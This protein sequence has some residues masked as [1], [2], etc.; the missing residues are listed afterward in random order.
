MRFRL[1]KPK[2]DAERS[3]VK[4]EKPKRS[5]LRNFANALLVTGIMTL[6][7]CGRADNPQNVPN[8]Q[9]VPPHMTGQAQERAKRLIILTREM[10]R[11]KLN[12]Y[13]DR[14][15][16]EG[17]EVKVVT[18][19]EIPNTGRDVPESIRNYLMQEKENNGLDYLLIVG[20]P[21]SE[22]YVDG[23]VNHVVDKEWEIPMRYVSVEG[24]PYSEG[25]AEL[26]DGNHDSINPTD[27]YYT[28]YDVDWDADR[29][30]I[31]G[32]EGVMNDGFSFTADVSVGRFPVR[33]EEELEVILDTTLNWEVKKRPVHSI[34]KGKY[35][36]PD[37]TEEDRKSTQEKTAKS[38]LPEVKD[39]KVHVCYDEPGG[40]IAYY[41]NE[42]DADFVT[43][44]S[45]GWFHGITMYGYGDDA[46]GYRL[47]YMSESI[48]KPPIFFAYA[49][50]TAAIDQEHDVLAEYM[51]KNGQ[52]VAFIGATRSNAD[53][54]FDLS[55]YAIRHKYKLGDALSEYKKWLHKREVM[56]TG[57]KGNLMMFNL[58]GDPTLSIS[59]T[60]KVR[61]SVP[62]A[63]DI[64]AYSPNVPVFLNAESAMNVRVKY[65]SSA[66]DLA[67]FD[68]YVERSASFSFEHHLGTLNRYLKS[69]LVADNDVDSAVSVSSITFFNRH[70]V[71][72]P[73][74]LDDVSGGEEIT[75]P[76]LV[77]Y[78]NDENV[79]I[80]AEFYPGCYD[81]GC[82]SDVREHFEVF[83]ETFDLS[84]GRK[85]PVTFVMPENENPYIQGRWYGLPELEILCE[86]C[87]GDNR[88]YVHYRLVE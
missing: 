37:Y 54:K 3:E 26:E 41:L 88:T 75:V 17:Y 1:R 56:T 33:T 55:D 22:D 63:V 21:D 76:V 60:P 15:K 65:V 83:S 35:C 24:K 18:L 58:F 19:E 28:N 87:S 4:R 71:K 44:Y 80:K 68:D 43:S 70:I 57:E 46:Y 2:N 36:A 25:P 14:K 66:I 50:L 48:E 12:E 8:L 38:Q 10:F 23:V 85:L 29:N 39:N 84:E 6:I 86:G 78:G 13:V 69:K 9:A 47:D 82:Q 81:D 77:L 74:E 73:A 32:E 53:K 27:E 72:G 45:H 42:D 59:E 16:E 62:E 20:D 5:R 49:C 7:G 11:E 79:T 67:I 31:Y 51:L 34:F 64:E 52:V 40:D 30:G 61:V